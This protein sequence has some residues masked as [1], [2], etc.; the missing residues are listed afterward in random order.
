MVVPAGTLHGWT[1]IQD[2]VT[3]LSM[4]ADPHDALPAGYVR[5][6]DTLTGCLDPV[7]NSEKESESQRL[8]RRVARLIAPTVT[9]PEGRV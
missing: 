3:D 5:S 2:Q 6:A 4:R 9:N 7:P 1:E 8:R